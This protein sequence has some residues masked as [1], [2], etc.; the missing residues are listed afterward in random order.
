MIKKISDKLENYNPLVVGLIG[1]IIGNV[2]LWVPFLLLLDVHH[3][4]A[5]AWGCFFILGIR[6]ISSKVPV[7]IEYPPENE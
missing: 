4:L 6:Y 7:V 2:I 3:Y 5:I 1:G